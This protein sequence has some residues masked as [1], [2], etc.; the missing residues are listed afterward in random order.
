MSSIAILTRPEGRNDA[1]SRDLIGAGWRVLVSPALELRVVP[2]DA[3]DLPLPEHYDLVVFVSGYAVR[4]YIT[5]LRDVAGQR[6]WPAS[7]PVATVGPASAK[8]LRELSDFCVDTTVLCPPPEAPTHDSEALWQVLRAQRALPKRVLIVRGTTGRDWLS[9]QF[10]ACGA[11]VARHVAYHRQAAVWSPTVMRQLREWAQHGKKATWLLTSGEGVSAVLANIRDAG[12][13]D[14]WRAS[15]FVVTHPTL[16]DRLQ[17]D[18]GITR[19]DA[20]IKNCL[21]ADDAILAAF[22]AV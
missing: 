6:E 13:E 21:P 17:G 12:L 14:W 5:Q 9:E 22:V 18:G 11:Q 2:V 8:A 10:V 3:A 19:T 7:V 1:L 16:A 4:T 15:A 20:M